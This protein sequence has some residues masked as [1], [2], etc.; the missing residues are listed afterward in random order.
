MFEAERWESVILQR[1]VGRENERMKGWENE[2]VG[3]LEKERIGG[4]EKKKTE[5]EAVRMREGGWKM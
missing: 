2:R 5:L 3:D 1:A 4:W